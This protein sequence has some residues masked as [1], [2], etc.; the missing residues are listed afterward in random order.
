MAKFTIEQVR[1]EFE[2]RGWQLPNQNYLGSG[3]PLDAICPNGHLTKKSR[4]V[5]VSGFG[6]AACN[7]TEKKTIE[8]VRSCFE[9]KGWQLLDI[10]EYRNGRTPLKAICPNGHEV[11][12]TW[13]EFASGTGCMICGGRQKKTIGYIKSRFEEKGWQL[14]ETEYL[15]G[16]TLLNVI[17]PN[18][19]TTKKSWNDFNQGVGC[20]IC[21]GHEKKTI[22]DIRIGFEAKGWQLL[23][24]NYV[25]SETRLRAICPNGHTT[26]K[27]LHDLKGGYGCMICCGKETKTIEDLRI[28]FEA[29]GWQ[30]LDTNYVNASTRLKVI[31][32]KG[33]TT[34]KDWGNFQQG[35]GCHVCNPHGFNPE[36][37]GTLYYLR[38]AH[39]FEYFYKIGITN[40][41]VKKRFRLET[42]PYEIIHQE[43]FTNGQDALDKELDI[44]AKYKKH[45]YNGEPFLR[46]G[47]T[48]LF[49]VD[50]LGLDTEIYG[51]G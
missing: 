50:I 30:L 36:L 12:K 14:L 16:K 28:A 42:K 20:A 9:E 1:T 43:F 21:Y 33:H 18:G 24:T 3:I 27:S 47:N 15:N 41:T 7:G 49:T 4:S 19:H 22:E 51:Q 37:S 8:Y 31:C 46:D 2:L 5:L 23:D 45:K 34:R 35:S 11:K 26:K 17:C 6:C 32:P 40:R 25:N 44:L 39:N 48:E 38:F 10:A 13:H 29:Q